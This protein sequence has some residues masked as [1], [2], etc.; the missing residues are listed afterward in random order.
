[1]PCRR[2]K[3]AEWSVFFLVGPEESSTVKYSECALINCYLY[4]CAAVISTFFIPLTHELDPERE[5]LVDL[6]DDL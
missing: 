6:D 2:K 5:L 4:N 1:M 3:K